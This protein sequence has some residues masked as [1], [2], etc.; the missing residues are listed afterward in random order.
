MR[1]PIQGANEEQP[2]PLS[3][4]MEEHLN[5]LRGNI[6]KIMNAGERAKAEQGQG[7]IQLLQQ[8]IP[9]V[10]ELE[11]LCQDFA[12]QNEDA[13]DAIFNIVN[14]LDAF[15]TELQNGLGITKS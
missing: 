5:F 9:E 6:P 12:K 4:K 13:R 15:V 1:Q 10:Q 3:E 7:Q 11:K 8:I 2:K 14:S